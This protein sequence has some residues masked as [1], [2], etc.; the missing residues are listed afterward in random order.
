[1]DI[2]SNVTLDKTSYIDISNDTKTRYMIINDIYHRI[3]MN[4]TVNIIIIML[5][6]PKTGKVS[7][8]LQ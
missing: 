1:M 7:L 5:I 2:H 8:R 4:D 6:N 3:I